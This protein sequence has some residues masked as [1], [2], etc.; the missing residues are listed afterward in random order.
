MRIV[1][2][3]TRRRMFTVMRKGLL[4][5]NDRARM[6]FITCVLLYGSF[7]SSCVSFDPVT[8]IPPKS[9]RVTVISGSIR[10]NIHGQITTETTDSCDTLVGE[11]NLLA[12]V[13]AEWTLPVGTETLKKEVVLE[14]GESVAYIITA[15]TDEAVVEVC[16]GS[17]SKRHTIDIRKPIGLMVICAN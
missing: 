7:F 3:H 2:M 5:R 16:D 4:I 17:S 14:T 9:T 1:P 11:R 8:Y 10:M 15:L 6:L 13:E 12:N